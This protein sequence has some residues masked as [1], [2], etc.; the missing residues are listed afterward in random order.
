MSGSDGEIQLKSVKHFDNNPGGTSPSKS[1][2]QPP[3]Y[4]QISEPDKYGKSNLAY[5]PDGGSQDRLDTNVTSV[6]SV[7][8][9]DDVNVTVTEVIDVH[10][11]TSN[12]LRHRKT[13]ENTMNLDD[14]VVQYEESS[15][16]DDEYHN[17]LTRTIGV[18]RRTVFVTYEDHKTEFWIGFWILLAVLYF[19]YFIYAMVKTFD[20]DD[21]G[22]MRL[23]IVTILGTVFVIGRVLWGKFMTEREFTI[24]DSQNPTFIKVRLILYWCLVIGT[25]LFFIAF[26]IVDVA[27]DRPK[28]LISAFG[29]FVFVLVFFVFSK[30]PTK[31]QF[32]PVFWGLALQFYFALLILRTEFGY[33]AFEWLGDRVREFL[34]HTDAGSEFVFGSEY[35]HHFFA[36]K[37]LTVIVF[38]SAMISVLYYLGVMQFVIRHLARFLAF[39][40]GTSPTESLNAAGNIF[41]GQSESPLMIRPFIKE[42]TKS[43]IHAVCTG[44][45]ATI[46]GSVMAA[47][48][49]MNVPPNHL[50][51]ASVMS[52]PAALAMAKLFYPE[53]KTSKHRAEDVYNM[54]KGTESNIIEAA[55]N[56]A[57]ISIK[58][59]ANIAVNLIAFL[60]ILKF[61]D[62]TLI[63][64]GHRV[65]MYDPELTFTL[66][67]SYLFYPVSWLL[68]TDVDDV[69]KVAGMIGT[70]TFLNEFVAY[71]ELS[72]YIGNTAKYNAYL[73]D[74]T[75]NGTSHKNDDIIINY[76]GEVLVGGILSDRSVV[77]ATYALC[78]FSNIGSIGIMLGALGALA[79]SRKKDITK[80]VVRAMIAGNVAC[81][82]TA[83]IAGLLYKG[84]I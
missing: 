60:A 68:G 70:K 83:C 81:F 22:S 82:M 3:A 57:S 49:L 61:L 39:C 7:V 12:G 77:V 55:S 79:P 62:S 56:G 46:A 42:M 5:V 18:T 69:R 1:D 75:Y 52:A 4:S 71:G 14:D 30:N 50:L 19:A 64:L 23:L 11:P 67:C 35:E 48:I 73:S 65:D 17:K 8:G 16:D 33:R 15:D 44:G 74:E 63:W 47:Y 20:V 13:H 41:I 31:V 27:I 84:P 80:V 37:V 29:M 40:L 36:F 59:I 54:E 45:F 21:E 78:G 26:I 34:A 2:D 38:F 58:L 51:S 25:I 32:R 6:P 72:T 53:T 76:T 43:E 24:L 28:N 9:N 66:I 10:I